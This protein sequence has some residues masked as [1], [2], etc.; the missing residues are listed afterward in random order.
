[1]FDKIKNFGKKKE[2]TENNL[3]GIELLTFSASDMDKFV[4]DISRYGS[5]KNGT[6]E[7]IDT[8]IGIFNGT[9]K[10]LDSLISAELVS[11]S[12]ARRDSRL[13]AGLLRMS[14]ICKEYFVKMEFIEKGEYSASKKS[15]MMKDLIKSTKDEM[16]KGGKGRIE[17][18]SNLGEMIRELSSSFN[19]FADSWNER[20]FKRD[21]LEKVVKTF[22]SRNAMYEELSEKITKLKAGAGNFNSSEI[23]GAKIELKRRE[24]Q[25]R[26]ALSRIQEVQGAINLLFG[27]IN[28][29]V[30]EK[31]DYEFAFDKYT[32]TGF[33]KNNVELLENFDR[34]G[35]KVSS[36]ERMISQ[37][38]IRLEEKLKA[39]ALHAIPQIKESI[40]SGE[41]LS[42]I[43]KEKGLAGYIQKCDD[44]IR[45]LGERVKRLQEPVTSMGASIQELIEEREILEKRIEK[46][47]ENIRIYV[48][49]NYKLEIRTG[50]MDFVM[51]IGIVEVK[52]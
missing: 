51:G 38:K 21:G 29:K 42:M 31:Y 49:K 19:N 20:V 12:T 14:S 17:D 40:Q 25:R 16:F 10:S 27:P 3:V 46:A 9:I 5:I 11:G 37:T 13:P 34:F 33:L 45:G 23:D 47:Q 4:S 26:T 1:M 32:L 41:L 28:G 35:E 44:N 8:A 43:K 7:R 50:S 6:M 39:K 52:R 24:R 2:I 36:L 15:S 22:T 30:S 48:E 18:N